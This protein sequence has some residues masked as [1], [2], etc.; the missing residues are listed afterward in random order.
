MLLLSASDL[1]LH[2][3]AR[4]EPLPF[5]IS[6]LEKDRINGCL[7]GI[8]HH[9]IGKKKVYNPVEVTQFLSILPVIRA[10]PIQP[11]DQPKK[12]GRPGAAE[13]L[14]AQSLGVTIRDI[15]NQQSRL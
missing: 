1:I 3:K 12:L 15:R 6:A 9:Q 14:L 10:K 11:I 2:F 13:R 4:N 8:P 7:G 5:S